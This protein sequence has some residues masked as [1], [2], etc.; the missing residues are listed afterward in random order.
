MTERRRKVNIAAVIAPVVFLIV[1][2]AVVLLLCQNGSYP[3]GAET[4]YHLHRGQLVLDAAAEGDFWV[5]YDPSYYNGTE[6][7]RYEAPLPAWVMALCMALA[8][9]EQLNG[10]LVFVGLVCFFGAMSWLFV[11]NGIGR[12]VFGAF[13]GILWFFMPNNL[14]VLLRKGAL[15]DSLAMVFLPLLLYAADRYFREPKWTILP[16]AA[17]LFLL[18]CLCDFNLGGLTALSMMILLLFTA[19]ITRQ[20]RRPCEFGLAIAAGLFLT[21]WW[22][23]GAIHGGNPQAWNTEL[24]ERCFQSLLLSLNP[25]DRLDTGCSNPYFS[26]AALILAL[27]GAVCGNRKSMPGFWTAVVIFL[28]TSS[29]VYGIARLIPAGGHLQMLSLFSVA[30]G[31]ILFG[32]LSWSSLRRGIVLLLTVLLCMDMVPSLSMI[33]GSGNGEAA[34]ARME[35]LQEGILIGEAKQITEQRMAF[36]DG[37]RLDSLGAWLVSDLNGRTDGALGTGW[38]AAHTYNNVTQLNRA[39]SQGSYLYLFDRC[40]LLGN[41]T[42]LID[43]SLL[44]R[45]TD[46]AENR[47]DGSNQDAAEGLAAAAERNGYERVAFTDRYHLYHMPSEGNWGT[48][49]EYRAIAIGDGASDIA[50][51]FPAF[52]EGDSQVLDSYTFEDLSAYDLIYLDGFTYDDRETAEE[53]VLRLSEANVRVIIAADGIPQDRDHSRRFLDVTCN[54]IKFT[55]GYP[56]LD[57]IDGVL[58]TDLFPQG[59]TKWNTVY[60]EGLDDCWGTVLENQDGV[61][62]DFYGT[63]KNRNIVMIGLNLTYFYGLTKDVSVGTL[64]N[65]A[66]DLS[67]NELP[68]RSIV[69][70]DLECSGETI[71]VQSPDS[72][73]NT[74]LA[75]LDGFH[76]SR[77]T[78]SE[79][80]LLV[81]Q[82]GKTVVTCRNSYLKGGVVVS[83]GGLLG[84]ALLCIRVRRKQLTTKK[85]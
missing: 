10:Y 45:N 33:Y 9:G 6:P 83:A 23:W 57:T 31:M 58:N 11:G 56:E 67:P 30:S 2:A 50:L 47:T 60:L 54:D 12:P 85:E 62:L 52:R 22:F 1:S 75:Y 43:I 25:V 4:M 68:K 34:A 53:L 76:C 19:L 7:L 41:D 66:M 24:L 49:A 14:F 55:N 26:V 16:L 64:L 40:K 28:C 77:E 38:K 18:I 74:G 37:G 80:G 79:N 46:D 48:T 72:D 51:S 71:T 29:A 21:G 69:P 17:G 42:V 35:E 8:G 73:V 3:D 27:F 78:E 65:H 61:N 44:G 20:I 32:F 63:V 82:E 5:G 39:L 84:L 36:L 15:G 81:V 59:Y 13:I 70:L